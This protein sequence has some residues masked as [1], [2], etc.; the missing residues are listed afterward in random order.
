MFKIIECPEKIMAGN[1]VTLTLRY[2]HTGEVLPENST[3]RIGYRVKDGAGILQVDDPSSANYLSMSCPVTGIELKFCDKIWRYR[4]ITFFPGTGISDMAIFSIKICSGIL[5]QG[6]YIDIFLGNPE[7]EK[8]GFIAGNYADD[9]LEF[10]YHIDTDNHF[11]PKLLHPGAKKYLQFI[12]DDGKSFPEWKSTGVK[13]EISPRQPFFADISLPSVVRPDG[14]A[15]LHITVYDDLG[16]HIYNFIS[17]IEISG[18]PPEGI[19]FKKCSFDTGKKGF[20]TLPVKFLK[21]EIFAG[22]K[23]FIGNLGIFTANPVLVSTEINNYIFWGDKHGHSR[24]SDGD[25]RGP[26]FFYEYA[27]DIRALDFAALA[28]HSFGLA[29]KDHWQQ[30]KRSIKKYNKNGSFVTLLGYEIMVSPEEGGLGHRNIYFPD[31][32]GKLAMADYQPGSGGSFKGENIIAYKDIWDPE[33]PKIGY[34]S[35][36][37]EFLKGIDFLWSAHHCGKLDEREKDI[38]D[39]FEVCS[40]WGVADE[41]PKQNHSN[42]IIENLFK[43]GFSPGLC[44][45]SDDHTTKAGNIKCGRKDGPIRYPSGMTAVFAEKLQRDEIYQ[46]LKNKRCYATTGARILIIPDIKLVKKQKKTSDGSNRTETCLSIKLDIAGTCE[47]DRIRV[48]KNGKML[49]EKTLTANYLAKFFWKDSEYREK[50]NYFIRI[51]QM[52]GEMAWLNCCP[53]GTMADGDSCGLWS[54]PGT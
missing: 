38:I 54:I 45:G 31:A 33:V 11:S 19:V 27:R 52:D 18:R 37:L 1:P 14:E 4:S 39:L 8:G 49:L 53:V 35:E 21:E 47:L 16:N 2:R 34:L 10:F 41:L 20:A 23:F 48:Y 36:F 25:S 3:L 12:S 28:D 32:E 30:L 44:G 29:V 5:K 15:M 43:E 13:L 40:E 17:K 6:D 22:L 51:S 50:D 24:L 42:I 9:P 46:N 26:D 7:Q